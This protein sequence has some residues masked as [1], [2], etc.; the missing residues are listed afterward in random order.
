MKM[1]EKKIDY[2]LLGPNQLKVVKEMEQLAHEGINKIRACKLEKRLDVKRGCL[3]SSV[4]SLIARGVL[5]AV[6]T[7]ADVLIISLADQIKLFLP[8][9]VKEVR[10][11]NLVEEYLLYQ[12]KFLKSSTIKRRQSN[13]NLLLKVLG[14]QPVIGISPDRIV[15]T[16]NQS[17]GTALYKRRTLNFL[18]QV[19]NYGIA[20]NYLHKNP[21]ECPSARISL[22]YKNLCFNRVRYEQKSLGLFSWLKIKLGFIQKECHV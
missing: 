19:F 10:L 14:D 8:P 18:S 7:D 15:A 16:I 22:G 3:Y 1:I 2:G 11:K 13:L 12:K 17:S 6:D 21:C 9:I 4:K 20:C 5:E